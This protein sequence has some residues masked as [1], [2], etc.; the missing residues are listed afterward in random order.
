MIIFLMCFKDFVF[1]VWKETPWITN[2][3][4]LPYDKQK[5]IK[6]NGFYVRN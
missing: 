5:S 2:A 3:H 4:S 6:G 1:K